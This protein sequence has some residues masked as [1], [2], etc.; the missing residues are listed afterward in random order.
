[1]AQFFYKDGTPVPLDKVKE[2]VMKGEAV[3]GNK[4]QYA[5]MIS[6]DGRKAKIPINSIW[7]AF[8]EE[9]L[10][11]PND[12]LRR[13]E[14][15]Y[16]GPLETAKA[17]VERTVGTS[18]VGISDEL[19]AEFMPEYAEEMRKRAI[20]NPGAKVASI[21]LSIALSG[22]ANAIKSGAK[23]AGKA[24]GELAVAEADDAGKSIISNLAKNTLMG[25][26]APMRGAESLGIKAGKAAAGFAEK[27]GLGKGLLGKSALKGIEYVTAG[28]TES[29]LLGMGEQMSHDALEGNEIT[30]EKL[31][32]AGGNSALFGLAGGS[33]LGAS[34]PLVSAGGRAII[35]G[36]KSLGNKLLKI[37]KMDE[38][39]SFKNKLVLESLGIGN[40]EMKRLNSKTNV[41]RLEQTGKTFADD[42]AEEVLNYRNKTGEAIDLRDPYESLRKAVKDYGQQKASTAAKFDTELLSRGIEP[43]FSYS[44]NKIGSM[45]NELK[46][47]HVGQVRDSA[48]ELED[49]FG[50]LLNPPKNLYFGVK[51]AEKIKQGVDGIVFPPK[52]KGYG[53]VLHTP[54]KDELFQANNFLREDLVR[55]AERYGTEFNSAA[56]KKYGEMNEK[57]YR[58]KSALEI[59]EKS[60]RNSGRLAP[61]FTDKIIGTAGAIAGGA[62]GG[63]GGAIVGS[64]A[65]LASKTLRQKAPGVLAHIVT[66]TDTVNSSINKA[67]KAFASAKKIGAVAADIGKSAAIK[68]PALTAYDS[69]KVEKTSD[70]LRKYRKLLSKLTRIQQDP[71][72][73]ASILSRQVDVLSNY[74]DIASATINRSI[75]AFNFLSSKL[76]VPARNSSMKL[77]PMLEI[78]EKPIISKPELNKFMKYVDAV[79]DPI[80]VIDDLAS[81]KVSNESIETLKTVYPLIFEQLK[82]SIIEKVALSKEPI[83]FD[84]R[85][86]MGLIFDF[87]SDVSLEPKFMADVQILYA[88]E[89]QMNE[90]TKPGPPGNLNV[91]VK[92]TEM[93]TTAQKIDRIA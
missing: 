47:S 22:A 19:A 64:A 45:I 31:L 71:E 7:D 6:P 8:N 66:R 24:I 20:A 38:K 30:A 29:A 36:G 57:Y 52:N 88:Q 86:L 54:S 44:R 53:L 46:S 63:I 43:D 65:G 51:D 3:L 41:K 91:S 48:A 58:L 10:N 84:K 79:E 68:V 21:P 2:A 85:I 37:A 87:V 9:Y 70:D 75:A 83:P 40:T 69:A 76:P 80:G 93:Q 4:Q 16:G 67:S 49:A 5:Y 50:V 27:A 60:E 72:Y 35:S 23:G 26:T 18:S 28:L 14:D 55:S 74:P 39:P 11:D 15:N 73:L 13:I 90:L 25:V 32:A 12:K 1:M 34:I 61:G 17:L 78:N 59:I 81:G 62:A 33:I 77:N 82:N 56:I 92:A 89:Q 42:V